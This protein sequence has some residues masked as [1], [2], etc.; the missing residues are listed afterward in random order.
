MHNSR[1]ANDR[2]GTLPT[3]TK[4]V[5]LEVPADLVKA[6][7]VEKIVV[8]IAGVEELSD[9]HVDVLLGCKSFRRSIV[10]Y[11]NHGVVDRSVVGQEIVSAFPVLMCDN[12]VTGGSVEIGHVTSNIG[13][14]EVSGPGVGRCGDSVPSERRGSG[15]PR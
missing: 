13:A 10:I 7:T 1:I 11:E 2:V 8:H 14:L 9:N 3:Q 4:V 15:V 5:R 12:V 6:D